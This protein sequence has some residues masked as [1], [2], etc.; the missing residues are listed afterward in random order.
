MATGAELSY[1]TSASAFPMANTILGSGL[2][3]PGTL[4]WPPQ[5]EVPVETLEDAPQPPRGIGCHRGPATRPQA[6]VCIRVGTFGTRGELSA[7]AKDLVNDHSVRRLPGGDVNDLHVL[8]PAP[9]SR[10]GKGYGSPARHCL[11]SDETRARIG[12]PQV[13]A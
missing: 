9:C 5:D 1:D 2:T 7:A 12:A 11:K 3:V 4:I 10:T 8:F 13:E 6:S